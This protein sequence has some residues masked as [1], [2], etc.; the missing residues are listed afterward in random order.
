[1]RQWWDDGRATLR[2]ALRALSRY[3]AAAATSVV[4]VAF[5]AAFVTLAVVLTWRVIF[6][7]KDSAPRAA[8]ML[9]AI[10]SDHER[11]LGP[12][13]FFGRRFAYIARRQTTLQCWVASR[14]GNTTVK[15]D[16]GRRQGAASRRIGR[17]F[18]ECWGLTLRLGREFRDDDHTK[19]AERIALVGER[20]WR[21]VFASDP[22]I[23]GSTLEIGQEVVRVVGIST[24]L[25][26][27]DLNAVDV[28]LP[29]TDEEIELGDAYH[30][31]QVDA[32]GRV[33]EGVSF[34]AASRE[35]EL[36]DADYV[37]ENP[38]NI[39]APLRGSLHPHADYR[40]EPA[41]R[42]VLWATCIPFVGV[43]LLACA[44][45]S[46]ILLVQFA[47]R[48]RATALRMALGASRSSLV[49]S[50]VVE[51]LCIA[52]VGGV[53][54]LVALR[55]LLAAFVELS[56]PLA[57]MV[58]QGLAGAA[59][60]ES[61][62]VVAPIVVVAG[63]LLIALFPGLAATRVSVHEVMQ[64]GARS[65]GG[66]RRVGR[67]RDAIANLLVGLSYL[68][69]VT[70]ISLGTG[71]SAAFERPLG[72]E[73]RGLVTASVRFPACE[74]R[75]QELREASGPGIAHGQPDSEHC[76]PQRGFGEAL[77]SLPFVER[78][79]IG[80]GAP[81]GMGGHFVGLY[82][83]EQER[84]LPPN[85]WPI[86]AWH[87]VE[88]GYFELLGARL[89]AGR[90]ID[91]RD[92]GRDRCA[93][94]LSE[95]FA[96]MYGGPEAVVGEPFY[97]GPDGSWRC[98]VVGVVGDM[99]MFAFPVA[100]LDTTRAT[101]IS[102]DV[103]EPGERETYVVRTSGDAEEAAA[104][105]AQWADES[106][107]GR[108]ELLQVQAIERAV[109][110][111]RDEY[112][113]LVRLFGIVSIVALLFAGLG[114]YGIVAYSVTMR[115]GEHALRMVLGASRSRVVLE[116]IAR[117]LRAIAPGLGLGILASLTAVPAMA[118]GLEM[119]MAFGVV[120]GVV[121]LVVIVSAV[122][123]AALVPAI[124]AG[125]TDPAQA[126]REE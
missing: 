81:V 29:A 73:T 117:Q 57:W 38:D 68:L 56:P 114:I 46:G 58:T 103:A 12:I 87:A 108:W 36:L 30:P 31:L 85:R 94:N 51:G 71:L 55:F 54:S 125:S 113:G 110:D 66:G 63:T 78:Y 14:P 19:G 95:S 41:K 107:A 34:E 52:L 42:Q 10:T 25:G 17:D 27:P 7:P 123:L 83:L 65:V 70:S 9:V 61:A 99:N 40:V 48:A 112:M 88:H 16:A 120:T 15:D 79:A 11:G 2:D 53:F 100:N 86:A 82:A 64:D 49:T 104:A 109:A 1:M 115:R 102:R 33:R 59:W 76:V 37:R 3:P 26:R 91:A 121:T 101:Y 60:D 35:F 8:E 77:A 98:T 24:S 89:V 119:P 72:Y 13:E 84:M 67:V 43:F 4:L 69:V 6:H 90:F 23:V 18:R 74:Q 111:Q 96:A 28:W 126:L 124:R 97:T 39:D 116:V 93:V 47:G 21:E 44:N 45:A 20:M 50:F 80:T 22:D 92:I 118:N 122:V 62:V 105:I 5:G 32:Y 106:G 75:Q